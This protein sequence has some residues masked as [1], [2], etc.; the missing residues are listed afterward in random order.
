M[1]R[2]KVSAL[3][4][5]EQDSRWIQVKKRDKSADGLFWYSVAST[6]VFCRPSCPSRT[7]NPENVLFHLSPAAARAAGYRACK[8]CKP[9]GAPL[10][11]QNAALVAKACRLI[12]SQSDLL[13]LKELASAVE[14]SPYYF[15]RLFKAQIGLTPKE[16]AVA[17]RAS[18]VRKSLESGPSITQ[19]IYDAGYNSNGRFYENA[20]GI[21]GM[22]PSQF[23]RGG[24]DEEIRF[25]VGQCSLGAILVA[26]SRKGVVSILIDDEPDTLLRTLQDRFPNAKLLGADK[27]YEQLVARVVGLVESPGANLDVPLDV[28]GTVFQ[29]KVWRALCKI[30][31][32]KTACYAEI[33]RR[34]GTP[35]AV[36]AVAGACAANHLAVAIPCHRVVRNDG[37][38]SGYRWG[39]ERK[40]ILLDR[41]AASA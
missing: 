31:A 28:R 20:A 18:R 9:E 15:H 17:H 13:S 34:I 33:A 16:Y 29:R 25:A 27:N 36:R 5:T 4:L 14:L 8:R 35:R 19:A 38:V 7:A 10:D 30:P 1:S 22:T 2:K 24:R 26:S 6:G 39:V 12:E 3:T 41:E 37:S 32:G 11:T 23:R 40:R 21:L